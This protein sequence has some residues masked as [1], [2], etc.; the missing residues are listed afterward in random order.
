M[1]TTVSVRKYHT[2]PLNT[3]DLGQY[4]F[5]ILFQHWVRFLTRVRSIPEL[6][7]HYR[8]VVN[9]G[10]MKIELR[11]SYLKYCKKLGVVPKPEKLKCGIRDV[12]M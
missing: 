12:A 3:S 4:N 5:N 6:N 11:Y 8:S 10:H 1:M 9:L 2:S 7:Y